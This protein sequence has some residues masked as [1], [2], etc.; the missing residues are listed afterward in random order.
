MEACINM[1]DQSNIKYTNRL[2]REKSP[3]LLQHAHNP[4]DWFP[5]GD[6]AF[7]KAA[8]D[9]KPIFLSIGYST[10]H[11]CHVME[12]ESFEDEEVA[13]LLNESYVSIK[14]D[15]EERPDVDHLYM[16][17]CQAMTGQGGWPLTIIMTPNK[18][19]F[20]S[21]TYFPKNQK[22]GRVGM[23][24]LLPQITSKW[25]EDPQKVAEVGDQIAEETTKRM[26]YN[27]E[28]EISE[29]TLKEAFNMYKDMFNPQ[30]G[31]FGSAPKFPTS[32]NL[33]YLLRYYHTSK[34][35]KAIEIVEKTLEAMHRGGIYDHIGF[36]FSRYSTDEEW[37]VPHFEKM[38]YD[39][40][41]LAITYIEAYQVTGKQKYAQIAEEIFTYVMRDMTD[42]GGAFYSAED[43]DSEGVEGKF[44]VWKPEGIIKVLG[45]EEGEL[46]CDLYDITQEGNFEGECI[47]NLLHNTRE[48]YAKHRN[49]SLEKLNERLEESRQ[50][51]FEH[52]EERI[53]PHKDDKILTSWNGL[54]ITA[55][56]KGAKALQQTKYAD[57]A[58]RAVKFILKNLR[59]A[60]GRLLAR[61]RDGEAAYPGYVDDYAFMVWGL[62]ELYEATFELEFL[63]QAI[64]LNE[65]MINLFWDDK[66][67]GFF[68]YGHDSEQLFTRM[69]EIYDGAVP[70][71]NS[72]AAL[73]LLRLSRYTG[74][75]ELQQKADDQIKAFSGAV[76][77]YPAGHS[78]FMTAVQFAYGP[79][80]EI[81]I[82][83][84][85]AHQDVKELIRKVQ[86]KFTP[87]TVV[88]LHPDGADGGKVGKLF[89]VVEG[90]HSIDGKATIY[91][92]ENYACQSPVTDINEVEI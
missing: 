70:S 54:M 92:C 18:K 22:Y 88:M 29:T 36:G 61:Y 24:G 81:V 91:V 13:R 33:S 74:S 48:S 43:A 71:G 37:L 32:H 12:R 17:V 15:R 16:A 67:G 40:A 27:F 82:S 41:L 23:T 65:E 44:Y 59:R 6:E 66:K 73:N 87:L 79:S 35:P 83:G 46:F 14:V 77:R 39:N 76:A 78:L 2:I 31:G 80:K 34:E 26:L 51:L 4:V 64:E 20:F 90:K 84:N 58:I 60:D 69:K 55:L 19:P 63:Q 89:P 75:E 52:R 47:P 42:P 50:K 62:I 25:K 56:A 45:E 5:W 38:L 30:Y 49:M 9:N 7:E 53:H 72:A 86:A 21:G 28:G 3:Y 1:T 85:P 11:W 68:F 10:C 8:K 57:T